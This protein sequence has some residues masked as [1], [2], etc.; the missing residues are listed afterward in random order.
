MST[1]S[2]SLYA[3]VKR[4]TIYFYVASKAFGGKVSIKILDKN[5]SQTFYDLDLAEYFFIKAN[6]KEKP[7]QWVNYQLSRINFIRG[8]L[9]S[10]VSFAD[11]ELELYPDNCR[12]HYVRGLAYGYI[13]T[14][15]SL[16]QAILDFEKF[17]TCFPNT[18]AGHN[19]LAWF[20]FRKGNMEK[21]IEVIEVVIEKNKK[22]PWLENTYGTALMN[23]GDYKKARIAFDSA[24]KTAELMTEEVWGI[25]YPG[26][27]PAV[28]QKGLSAMRESIEKNI[29]ELEKLELQKKK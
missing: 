16:N 20:W 13:D 4:D 19:D 23:V 14:D 27:D 12:T 8:D 26:N 21:V 24:R 3:F 5:Y 6:E 28:Y 15:E 9:N 25:A 11:K 2:F 22:N 7:E 29:N 18:W 17:N 1:L 10:A